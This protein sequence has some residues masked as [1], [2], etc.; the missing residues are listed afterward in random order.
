MEARQQSEGSSCLCRMS[1]KRKKHVLQMVFSGRRVL[2]GAR[3]GVCWGCFVWL[4]MGTY[5]SWLI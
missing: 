5:A 2:D 3:L 1:L 4:R